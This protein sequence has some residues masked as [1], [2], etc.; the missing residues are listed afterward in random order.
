[1]SSEPIDDE[2]RER[3][4]IELR[5]TTLSKIEAFQKEWGLR[6][7]GVTVERILEELFADDPEE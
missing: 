6:S 7:R 1:M 4:T 3:V 2:P 5:L